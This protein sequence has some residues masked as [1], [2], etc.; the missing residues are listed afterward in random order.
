MDNKNININRTLL[1]LAGVTV[2]GLALG[3][4]NKKARNVEIEKQYSMLDDLDKLDKLNSLSDRGYTFVG[5]LVGISLSNGNEIEMFYKKDADFILLIDAGSYDTCGILGSRRVTAPGERINFISVPSGVKG[6]GSGEAIKSLVEYENEN[7]GSD[8]IFR[9]YLNGQE[10]MSISPQHAGGFEDMM[11]QAP[12][13]EEE[14][15]TIP[16]VDDI[17][18]F[19]FSGNFGE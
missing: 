3:F 11:T 9:Q 12:M 7:G 2:G 14:K 5:T 4:M 18:N 10:E 16:T 8:L 1:I 19:N 15:M 13:M 17:L 6:K